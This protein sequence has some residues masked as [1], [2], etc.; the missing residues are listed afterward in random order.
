MSMGAG[1]W[2]IVPLWGLNPVVNP[3]R[4]VRFLNADLMASDSMDSIFSPVLHM[5][6]W[7][8]LVP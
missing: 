7:V 5:H 8:D 4:K 1:F 2:V 6:L 3:E